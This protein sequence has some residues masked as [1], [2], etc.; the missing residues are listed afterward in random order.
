MRKNLFILLICALIGCGCAKSGDVRKI[1][2]GYSSFGHILSDRK[3][4]LSFIKDALPNKTYLSLVDFNTKGI[5][6][7]YFHECGLLGPHEVIPDLDRAVC[8]A[9]SFRKNTAVEEVLVFDLEDKSIA[10]KFLLSEGYSPVVIKKPAWTDNVFVLMYSRYTKSCL[11]KTLNLKYNSFSDPKVIGNFPV[12]KAFF[13]EN[14]PFLALDIMNGEDRELI[15]YNINQDAIV[16]RYPLEAPAV[17]LK[18]G[19]EKDVVYGLFQIPGELKSRIYAFGLKDNKVSTVAE[20]DGEL[21][22]MLIDRNI[23]YI[24]GKDHKRRDKQTKYWLYPRNLYVVDRSRSSSVDIIDWTRRKGEFIGLN[25][26]NGFIFYAVTDNDA[27]G[28][29]VIKNQEALRKVER[30]IL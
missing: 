8:Y 6:K 23:F 4:C 13:M 17:E 16:Q 19:K 2:A 30:L 29:W 7:F 24:I 1:Y 20:I 10:A 25:A 11:L 26:E 9:A 14:S 12:E 5:K 3:Y 15:V 21:E 22:S 28:I 27:P 18:A